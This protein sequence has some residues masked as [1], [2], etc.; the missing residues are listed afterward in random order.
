MANKKITELPSEASPSNDDVLAIVND[1]SGTPETRQVTANNLMGLAP[2]QSVAGRTGAVTLSD[3]D[4][5]GLGT[6]ATTASTD[7]SSAFFNIVTKTG[8]YTLTDSENGKVILCNSTDRIDITVPSG[9][10]SGFN[11]RVV[12]GDTGR[13]RLLTNGTTING[14]TSGS[15]APNAIIGQNGVVDLVPVG[16]NAYTLAGDI[17]YLFVYGNSKSLGLD[18]V[19]DWVDVGNISSLNSVNNY[20]ISLWI[21]EDSTIGTASRYLFNAHQASSGTYIEFYGASTFQFRA[22]NAQAARNTTRPSTDAWHNLVVTFGSSTTKIYSDGVLLST[23][24]E[25][26]ATTHASAGNTFRIGARLSNTSEVLGNID[27]FAIY[28]EALTDGG[29]SDGATAGGQIEDIY[30]GR[31]SGGSGGSAGNPGDLS[32][33][34]GNGNGGLVNW[35]RFEDSADDLIGSNDGTLNGTTYSTDTP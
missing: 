34:Q 30:N 23:S 12:Q 16:S 4:I 33:F 32:S 21:K 27:E 7:Y 8:H 19:D 26:S 14:Y 13:V 29:V 5:S 15:N 10:T 11:C 35:W 1:P 31:A 24:S 18:G 20:S 3:T 17:D 2:V 22:S 6:A 25:S 28:T 9:L